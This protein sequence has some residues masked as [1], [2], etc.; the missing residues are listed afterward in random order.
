MMNSSYKK[1]QSGFSLIELLIAMVLS[2][3]IMTA[4]FALMRGS[5]ITANT[6]YEMTTANQNLRN[7]QEFLM[8]DI[9][10][11]GDGLKGIANVWLPT[12]FVKDYLSSR[13]VSDLDPSNSGFI[14]VGS[15]LS[16]DDV[17]A[18]VNVLGANP[19]TTIRQRTDRITMISSDPNFIPIDLP[20][21]SSDLSSGKIQI[22]VS[23]I[24]D[25]SVGEI[26]YVTSGG[27]GVFGTVTAVDT[28][29]NSI[30]WGNGDSFGLNRT[31]S[32]GPL[33]TGTNNN[34][35]PATLK[36]MK[37]VHYFA[38]ADGKL[39]RRVFGVQDAGFVDSVIAEH[40]TTLQFR[41]ILNP[42]SSEEIFQ[43]PKDQI[44][45]SEASLVRM[46]EPALSVET[47]YPLQDGI[48]HQIDGLTQ[49]GVRNVQFL[50][51]PL[52]MDSAGNTDLPNPGP[53]PKITPVPTPTSVPTP[54]PVPSPVASPT[55]SPTPNPIGSPTPTPTPTP[56]PVPT[57][58]PTPVPTPIPI[59]K[60]DG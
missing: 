43:Q 16:D 27:S 40:L 4:A 44:A 25:F 5:I 45:L 14:T 23:R 18:N 6:N 41:Y 22:P 50:E 53:T 2:L 36:R 24:G 15:I 55:P 58:A 42:A 1:N 52:P 28:S 59:G 20:A 46:I 51:A 57:P 17:P 31:G 11:A 21:N 8:R 33:A 26:Y 9:L 30:F 48:K 39:V 29:S 12:K 35:N 54:T 10:V 38:D 56:T 60:G 47:A 37:I 49:I 3:V 7:S 19:P 34:S 32:T 13:P